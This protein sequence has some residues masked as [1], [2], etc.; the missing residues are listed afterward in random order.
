MGDFLSALGYLALASRLRRLSDELMG[1]TAKFYKQ[2]GVEFSPKW[3]GLYK[4]LSEQGVLTVGEAATQL[5]LTHPAIS[6]MSKELIAENLLISKTDARD[7]RRRT[8]E[9][10]RKGRDLAGKMQPTWIAIDRAS[11]G[12]CNDAGFDVIEKLAK[13]EE[14]LRSR[15]LLNRIREAHS[16]LAVQITNME[17][18][19]RE[20]FRALNLAWIEKHFK[21]E[22][23]DDR[24]LRN[25]ETE[26]IA[27]GGQVL[28]ALK[29]A[30]VVGVVSIKPM[31]QQRWEL[32]K[33]AVDPTHHGNGIGELLTLEAI[34][35]AKKSGAKS[36]FL[37]TSTKLAPAI[38]L[39]R[40]L[41]FVEIDIPPTTECARTDIMFELQFER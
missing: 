33:L 17:P 8:L 20:K 5:G 1:D 39:Y 40:K 37:E 6:Q 16:M 9:L 21:I 4:L 28:V 31:P 7:E 11:R 12:I 3:F 27:K 36:I 15:P 14:V 13:V 22:P 35:R 29:A 32:M 18:A 26:I 41:G 30:Q 38:K 10:T 23:I 2:H 25:P 24:M 34:A 19:H